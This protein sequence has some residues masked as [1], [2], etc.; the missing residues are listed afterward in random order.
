[1]EATASSA[2]RKRRT[3][4][5]AQA[6]S[7]ARTSQAPHPSTG[8]RAAAD[9]PQGRSAAEGKAQILPAVLIDRSRKTYLRVMTGSKYFH[10]IPM[11]ASGLSVI[12]LTEAECENLGLRVIDYVLKKAV[13]RFRG[14]GERFGMTAEAATLLARLEK[15]GEKIR[16]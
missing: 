12:K 4:V 10:L 3:A 6:V 11:D 16:G 7:R 5:A 8:T 13:E 9:G 14:A 15:T 1:M 2:R